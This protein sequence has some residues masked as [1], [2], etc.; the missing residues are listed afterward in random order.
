MP[1]PQHFL[2]RPPT[3]PTAPGSVVPLIALD[4][5]PEW[6]DIQGVSREVRVDQTVGMVNMGVVP[7]SG[8]ADATHP[9]GHHLYDVRLRMGPNPDPA[10]PS[11]ATA[12]APVDRPV[13][14]PPPRPRRPLAGLAASMYASP[15]A[16]DPVA[17]EADAARPPGA[18]SPRVVVDAPTHLLDLDV[19]D[20]Q[21]GPP[22]VGAE[23][24]PPGTP[25]AA[26]A[27]GSASSVAT[28]TGRAATPTHGSS[29]ARTVVTWA[30]APTVGSTGASSL[31]PPPPYAP[32]EGPR[33]AYC[34]H[35]CHHG[36]CKW[37]RTCRYSHRMPP[38]TEELSSV[39]LSDFPDWWNAAAAFYAS[40][41]TL[42]P[43]MGACSHTVAPPPPPAQ[44]QQQPPQ[45]QQQQQQRQRQQLHPQ[46]MGH[47]ALGMEVR[48]HMGCDGAGSFQNHHAHQPVRRGDMLT[49]KQRKTVE[50]RRKNGLVAAG[51]R[52]YPLF[53]GVA[54]TPVVLPPQARRSS[55]G[56]SIGVSGEGK[57]GE[58]QDMGVPGALRADALVE[59]V[60]LRQQKA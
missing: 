13:V 59:P 4:Q 17:G 10:P 52:G 49:K 47:P 60:E 24:T 36:T 42:S 18:R 53:M 39:G 26:A 45:Q 28:A 33:I 14:L 56:L 37:G 54:D 41:G 22:G 7:L 9:H 57:L 21:Y 40:G 50:W 19:L 30:T 34:R 15:P 12:G 32:A 58:T 2:I 51:P 27:A 29:A 20:L 48:M 55:S 25:P 1:K 6:L 11:A 23:G 5:L 38:S 31:P 8:P 44:R 35:W 46:G 43:T 3:S 16:P